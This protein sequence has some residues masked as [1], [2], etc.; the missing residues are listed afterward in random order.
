MPV[1]RVPLGTE[2]RLLDADSALIIE[3]Q[4]AFQL[5]RLSGEE[6]LL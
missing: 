6:P 5:V 4:V 2:G 1:S 3:V